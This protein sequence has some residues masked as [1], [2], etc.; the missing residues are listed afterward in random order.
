[1]KNKKGNLG[2]G[3]EKRQQKQ[4][5][6]QR[7]SYILDG[8]SKEEWGR[9][10]RNVEKKIRRL[11]EYKEAK[12]IVVYWP[13]AKE[14]DLRWFIKKAKEEGKTI[15]LP[16]LLAEDRVDILE[17]KGEEELIA[18]KL[19]I[20]QPDA[21][22]S[23]K[24]DLAEIDLVIVPG[25]AFD[26]EGNRLGRGKGWYDAFIKLLPK[27]AAII[28]VALAPQIVDRLPVEPQQDEKVEKVITA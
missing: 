25:L 14:V 3:G 11:P 1:M 23:R 16:A 17:F 6:R 5:L 18:G 7:I 15:G 13:L 4:E 21:R 26:K 10:S 20:Q 24:I 2:N 28:G 12:T 22:L 8:I 9:R 19:G 27:K